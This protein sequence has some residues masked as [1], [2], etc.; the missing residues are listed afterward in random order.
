MDNNTE[1]WLLASRAPGLGA[2]GLLGLLKHFGGIAALFDAGRG[3]LAR[4]GLAQE[5][6]RFLRAP[7][8]AL[9]E[10]DLAWL[11]E[12]AHTMVTFGGDGYPPQLLPLKDAPPLLFVKGD[13]SL[14]G[15]PQIAIVGSRR[16]TPA[17][18]ENARHL[19]RELAGSGLLVTSGLARG[20]DACAHHG[21]L[22]AGKPTIA[23][24]ATGQ[25]IIYPAENKKLAQAMAERGALV[26]EFPCGIGPLPGHFPRRNRLISGLALGVVVVEAGERSGSL[27]TARLAGEQG[28]EVFAVPGSPRNP[29]AKGC[30]R[31]IQQGAKLIADT[32][33]VLIELKPQIEHLLKPEHRQGRRQD[34]PNAELVLSETAPPDSLDAEHLALLDQMGFE[35]TTVDELVERTNLPVEQVSAMLLMLELE[36]YVGAGGGFYQRIK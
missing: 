11:E 30:H 20:I 6:I 33:D 28:R 15:E 3:E 10:A 24:I 35:Q 31:L 14:I 12:P 36:G 27:I 26:S 2:V 5:T 8:P 32:G 23:V 1:Q 17:G 16:P 25:D 18:R 34:A 9:I 29:L 4:A 22:D 21:A 7:D 19:A 13:A